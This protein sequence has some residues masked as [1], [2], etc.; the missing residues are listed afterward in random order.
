[1]RSAGWVK[2]WRTG[3]SPKSE[4]MEGGCWLSLTELFTVTLGRSHQLSKHAPPGSKNVQTD[5]LANVMESLLAQ[6]K[7]LSRQVVTVHSTSGCMIN[8]L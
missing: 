2:T 8:S 5:S 1:M 4:G 7:L 3:V 6:D